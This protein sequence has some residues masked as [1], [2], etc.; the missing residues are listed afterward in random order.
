[1][2]NFWLFYF[3]AFLFVTN[4]VTAQAPRGTIITR[5]TPAQNPMDPNGD[6]FVYKIQVPP[7][8]SSDGY[9]VDEFEFNMFGIPKLG[10]GDVN[11]DNQTGPN[12][13]V[14]DVIPDTQGYS[15]YAVR[16][17]DPLNAAINNLIFRFRIGSN[18]NSIESWHI[19][20]DI[21]GLFGPGKD[22]NATA[23]NPG[24]E[25]DITLIKKQNPG[26][27]ITN[28]DGTD[29]C[30]NPFQ[31]YPLASNFQ[32]SVADLVTCGDPDYF[33]D[34]YVP[35]NVIAS[36]FGINVNTGLRYVATTSSSATC[37]MSGSTSDIAGIDNDNP[38]YNNNDALAYTSLI[39]AQ[40]PTA[41]INLCETCEG[42]NTG[43][44]VKPTINPITVGNLTVSGTSAGAF[45]KL[46]V[47]TNTNTNPSLITDQSLLT[48]STTPRES[49]IVAVAA[50]T[51]TVTLN[52]PLQNYDKVV[53]QTQLTID[54]SSACD[55]FSSNSS[56]STT[57]AQ[58]LR[59][60]ANPQNLTTPEDTALPI[61]LTAT[62][63]NPL[64]VL[65]YAV[66][67]LPTH[68][69][70]SCT[71]CVNPTYTPASNYNGSDSFTFKATDNKSSE[72]VPATIT[73]TVSPVNDPPVANNQS[74]TTNEDVALPITLTA[75]DVDGNTLTYAIGAPAHGTLSCNNCVNPTYTPASNYFGPDSFTFTVFDGTINSN[76]ATI[77]MTVNSV[78]D[79]PVATTLNLTTP[80][81]TALGITL[82]GTDVE[83]ALLTYII[84]SGPTNGI[85]T[86]S[87]SGR[88]YTPNANYNGTETFTYQVN[89]GGA[90]S[91]IATVTILVTPVNDAPVAL[92]QS[93]TT[94]EDVALPIT[95]TATHPDIGGTIVSY[96]IVTPP[97]SG[98]LSG[99]A[100]N[101][102]Y[103][104]NANYNGLDRFTFIANDGTDNSNIATIFITVTPVSD[105]PIATNQSITTNEDTPV[106]FTI[107]GSDP[108]GAQV[109]YT[110]LSSPA[111]GT[112][113]GTAP[114]LTYSPA[115][116]FNGPDSFTFKVND[117]TSDSN[118]A[119]V[120][121]TVNPVNDAP[122]AFNQ[123][124]TVVEEELI[125]ITLVGT[126][127]DGDL[128]T[129]VLVTTPGQGILTG[130][131][132]NLS[133]TPND[134]T[135][136]SNSD[137]FT[138]R[139]YDSQGVFS[140]I[141]TVFIN[142]DPDDD[143][144]V[145]NDQSV[146]TSEDTPVSF[147]I[148]GSDK[149]LEPITYILVT[150]P[151]HGTLSG[152]APNL[153]YTPDANY[154]GPDS[155]TFKVNDT[156]TDSNI[157]TVSITVNPVNDAPVA[158][159]KTVSY[160]LNTPV[161]FT[162]DAFDVDGNP[163]T[164][165]ILTTPANGTVIPNPTYPNATY[166][167]NPGFNLTNTMTF[168]VNDGTVNSNTATVT[169]V[170][171]NLANDAPV[172]EDQTITVIEDQIKN[173]TLGATDPDPGDVIT[174]TIVTPPAHGTLSGTGQN[175]V[176]TPNANY[177]GPDSFVFNASDGTL[178]SNGTVTITVTPV[179]D[180]PVANNQVVTV[181]EDIAKAITLTG[182]DVEGE[183]LGFTVLTQPTHGV[184]TGTAPNLTYTPDLNYFGPDSFTFRVNAGAVNSNVATV[185][186]N[187]VP[188]NDA[189][190]ATDQPNVTTPEETSLVIALSATDSDG[191]ALTYTVVTLPAHGTLSCTNCA[192]PIYTP[193]LNYFGPDSFTFKANDGT[194]DSNVATVS[195]TVTPVNDA[196]IANNQSVTVIEDT[197]RVITLTGSDVDGDPLTFTIVTQ[198]LHGVLTVT[199]ATVTYTPDPNDNGQD[200]FTFQVNDGTLNSNI[201]TVSIN[202]VPFNDPPIAVNNTIIT[203]EDIAVT[204]SITDNDT[205]SDG[206]IDPTTVDLDPSTPAEDKTLTITGE[207]TY[208]VDNTGNV[209]FT[210]ALNYNGVTTLISY[211]VKDNAG[212]LSNTASI[213]ITVNP[214]NDA[215][216]VQN[217]TVTINEDETASICFTVTDVE[218]D[219]SVFTGGV[220]L[221][222]H[223]SPV[224]DPAKGAFCFLYTPVT[225][226][227][228][229][230]IVEVTVCDKND[231]TICST[232]TI[233]I[234]IT[235][236]N[237]PPVVKIGGEP[238]D[239]V[240]VSTPE[241]TPVNICFDGT[242][243][244]LDNISIGTITNTVGGG[245]LTPGVSGVGQ[246]C[247]TFTPGT[248]FTG[249]STWQ[250]NVCDDG[251]PS[252]CK[253]IT[254]EITVTP[255]QDAPVAVTQTVT[256]IEDTPTPITLVGT[257]P[258]ANDILTYTIVTPPAH[259]TLTGSGANVTYTPDLN[260]TGP[261]SFT[262][263]V[264][265]GTVDSNVSTIGITVTPVNDAPV[266][267]AIPTITTPEDTEVQICL[268][269]SDAEGDLITYQP[270]VMVSGG[271]SMTPSSV[272]N[273]CY[274][275]MP[276]KDFNGD[277]FWKFTVCDNGN[278]QKCTEV[279]VKINVTPVNDPPIAVDDLITAQSFVTIN[280][281]NIIANDTDVDND[282]LVLTVTPVSGPYHGTVTM[283]ADGTFEYKSNMDFM[284]IDSVRYRVCDTGTPSLCDEGL[285]VIEVGPAPFK[286]YNGL[287]P[288]GDNRND[289]WRI[290]GIEAFPN[291]RVRVFD[292]YNNLIFETTGYNNDE[293]TWR[294]QTNHSMVGA[295]APEGTYFYS[296]DL[297]D[298]SGMYSGYIVLKKN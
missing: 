28:I 255:V 179:N 272:F 20:L 6:G 252:L 106:S 279:T 81:D 270:P 298:G 196:P 23:D 245:T 208:V 5:A 251:V 39:E 217:S 62:D 158:L 141:A 281:T 64:D 220:S 9:Y 40:C 137:S 55:S 201:A 133:Y 19:L 202:V 254:I 170:F 176:Y 236:V 182:S 109:T 285:V 186:I 286:I 84:V 180:P 60:V 89:D 258:D 293:N 131:G 169:F 129:Y 157:A 235:P 190:I 171:N 172:A 130:T 153:T 29:N 151:A 224:L 105:V 147:V 14:T 229:Q 276:A 167:P 256:A 275:F 205:D 44:G 121:I 108:D 136:L 185:S 232:G 145:A 144:P 1:M 187:V 209:T 194:A 56:T 16:R 268:G 116:D 150:T 184:L 8:F 91:N 32:I 253:T 31:F 98:T 120:S 223:G 231:P 51:W 88:T 128:L 96:S 77:S 174:F 90:N 69:T 13:G 36:Q 92:D 93:L 266:I 135:G 188:V 214:I 134:F 37:S 38:I 206:T 211:T 47:Y 152:T 125:N 291:N 200:S 274:V 59:P 175:I 57:I 149:H 119:T 154:T 74:L 222:G 124:I 237:D 107:I 183:S 241:D 204:F 161:N 282:A 104:P 178:S 75:T 139:V 168:R 296:V 82:S 102:V 287:S 99:T 46:S 249:I 142:I 21:D 86:G 197:P 68:G 164:Y 48:W 66:V 27:F 113:S 238:V 290:D 289:Y 18:A 163:L 4:I 11:G 87:G 85:L 213:Q 192:N 203:N 269:V 195:I 263:K 165:S 242:D 67:T 49:K 126:D 246:F 122:I 2:K 189:P 53:A 71:N 146:A 41:V 225:N 292:R 101:L 227:N 115:P 114:N 284:G 70:L 278:P 73:I 10:A 177:N 112:L 17:P 132:A 45:V 94:L 288:N 257:D 226:Y 110:I 25:V 173:I 26:V 43:L 166:T 218:N 138:F 52:G 259:G 240:S 230:D 15:V 219:P 95:L 3:V 34:F 50:G 80:E 250:V 261:D 148:V 63:G 295:N 265:D 54:G 233:T 156:K 97:Q 30:P 162:F 7:G 181:Q 33:Y 79:L 111:H 248:N 160:L 103:T 76:T 264:N 83:T 280:P 234:N 127:V 24:F 267:S 297:G 239:K 118:I 247:F 221:G 199:G 72:S 210:P 198:P 22:T 123:T 65:T 262:F 260:Y 283:K 140:N 215:P 244:E 61:T 58:N 117:G 193:A 191:D 159:N 228:G 100:P 42:F 143:I 212:D 216:V 277:A 155:F 294:G 35:F 243:P 78:N 12:C 273:F 207:G 271:G